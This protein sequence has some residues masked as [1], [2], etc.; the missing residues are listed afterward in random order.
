MTSSATLEKV[1]VG[2]WHRGAGAVAVRVPKSGAHHRQRGDRQ[3]LFMAVVVEDPSVVDI[4]VGEDER[5]RD[6][7]PMRLGFELKVRDYCSLPSLRG[8]RAFGCNNEPRLITFAKEV[9]VHLGHIFNR[10]EAGM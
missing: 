10:E 5:R 7:E 8:S 4:N 6:V 9:L 1:H 2:Q 3:R